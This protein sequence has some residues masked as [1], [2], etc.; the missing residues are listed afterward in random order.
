MDTSAAGS[1]DT[2]MLTGSLSLSFCL[3]VSRGTAPALLLHVREIFGAELLRVSE[4]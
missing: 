3:S 4:G 1:W 2:C